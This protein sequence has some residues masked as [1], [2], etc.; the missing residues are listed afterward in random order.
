MNMSRKL[1]S[2][3]FAAAAAFGARADYSDACLEVTGAAPECRVL[4]NRRVY[5]FTDTSAAVS[6][7]T[8]KALTLEETLVVGGGGGG[9]GGIGGGGGGGGVVHSNSPRTVSGGATFV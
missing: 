6:V 9:G 5:I 7:T 8:K 4:G 1:A 3:L 2:C